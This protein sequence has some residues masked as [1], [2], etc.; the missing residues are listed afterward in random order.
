MPMPEIYCLKLLHLQLVL[1]D[2][3]VIQGSS[4]TIVMTHVRCPGLILVIHARFP[5]K[6]PVPAT[7]ANTL[8]VEVAGSLVVLQKEVEQAIATVGNV[9]NLVILPEIVTLDQ[10]TRL[11]HVADPARM[12]Q[13]TLM[14]IGVH[15]R[16]TSDKGE[17]VTSGMAMAGEDET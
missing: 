4:G 1:E 10:K 9:G 3:L 11:R 17:E 8:M 2:H 6:I 12:I 15:R 14:A 13:V 16:L 5:S 7:I